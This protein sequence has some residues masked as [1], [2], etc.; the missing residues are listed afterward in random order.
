MRASK[1]KKM[2]WSKEDCPVYRLPVPSKRC[3]EGTPPE[4]LYHSE[5]VLLFERFKY[6]VVVWAPILRAEGSGQ[7]TVDNATVAKLLARKHLVLDD[8][9]MTWIDEGAGAR[10]VYQESVVRDPHAAGRAA[11]GPAALLPSLTEDT[12]LALLVG[13]PYADPNTFLHPEYEVQGTASRL[14]LTVGSP[15]EV[16][17]AMAL[18]FDKVGAT[19]KLM[20]SFTPG[21]LELHVRGPRGTGFATMRLVT[22]PDGQCQAVFRVD[23]TGVKL[24]EELA[25]AMA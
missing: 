19:T 11:T 24:G 10:L 16:V 18:V 21:K 25:Q 1:T 2:T 3:L 15:K 7:T 20:Q 17:A 14:A 23:D 6:W 5:K 8:R 13:W 9:K 4:M 12:T 22:L